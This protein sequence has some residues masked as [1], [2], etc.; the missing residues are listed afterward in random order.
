M[1]SAPRRDPRTLGTRSRWQSSR[2]A[3]GAVETA[4][5]VGSTRHHV[6]AESEANLTVGQTSVS[7]RSRVGPCHYAAG[8]PRED[9]LRRVVADRA[10]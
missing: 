6:M 9:A 8:S 5:H 10:R 7:C 2:I 1:Q 4:P 3:G